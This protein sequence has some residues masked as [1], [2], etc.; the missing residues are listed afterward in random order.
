M[1]ILNY[2]W[3]YMQQE[4][5]LR[6]RGISLAPQKVFVHD[7]EK[8]IR[9]KQGEC[10]E[11]LVTLDANEQ[12]EDMDSDIKEMATKLHLFDIAKERHPEGVPATY[13]R[14]NTARRIVLLLGSEK[15]METVV[16]YGMAPTGYKVLGDHQAQFLDIDVVTLLHLN[17]HDTTCNGGQPEITFV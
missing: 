9:K 14:V 10:H 13:S 6:S 17:K 15:V 4:R 5:I 12:W 1:E 8:F 11:M 16:A 3:S 2:Y 7:M